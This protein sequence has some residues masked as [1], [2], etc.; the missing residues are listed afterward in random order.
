MSKEKNRAKY[1]VKG[2]SPEDGAL[3]GEELAKLAEGGDIQALDKRRVFEAIR[4]DEN[5]PLRRFYNWDV[6]E[7]SLQHWLGQTAKLIRSVRVYY[8][9]ARA[10]VPAG[11]PVVHRL[12]PKYAKATTSE[13]RGV[14]ASVADAA[15]SNA[16]MY[17][18]IVT[19]HFNLA[20]NAI[21][22]LSNTAL[23][24][25]KDGPLADLVEALLRAVETYEARTATSSAAE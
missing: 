1:E 8:V 9:P 14:Y 5:H 10:F 15:R 11:P 22:T 25:P 13:G 18:T 21:R 6:E 12:V 24:A 17:E 20:K 23:H 2:Y 3:I 4:A 7:A 16:V 19:N